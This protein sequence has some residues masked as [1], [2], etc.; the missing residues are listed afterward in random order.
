MKKLKLI[1]KYLLNNYLNMKKKNSKE[2]TM[3]A[4]GHTIL[5]TSC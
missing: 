3:I 2:E 5:R 4:E 1:I